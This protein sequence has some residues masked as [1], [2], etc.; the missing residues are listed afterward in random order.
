MA[1]EKYA[2]KLLDPRWKEK[3]NEVVIRDNHT[4][5]YC[6]LTENLQV[7]HICYEGEPWDINSNALV[8]LCKSCHHAGHLINLTFL[9]KSLLNLLRMMGSTENKYC[10]QIL[11]EANKITLKYK[12]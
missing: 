3:R 12:G 2:K 11:R 1:N 4:C 7:H 5:M 6:G 8:T 9:E 10:Q